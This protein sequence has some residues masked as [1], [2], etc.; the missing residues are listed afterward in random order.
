MFLESKENNRAPYF[1]SSF[2]AIRKFSVGEDVLTSCSVLGFP[3]PRLDFYKDGKIIQ[4]NEMFSV[5]RK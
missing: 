4:N 3:Q 1:Q 5:G 2:P